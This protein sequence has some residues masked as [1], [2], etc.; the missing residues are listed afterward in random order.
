MRLIAA[1]LPLVLFFTV[2]EIFENVKIA[3]LSAVIFSQTYF[4]A[5]L[6]PSL[7]RQYIT[8][9]FLVLA[10]FVLVR[11]HKK[12]SSRVWSWTIPLVLFLFGLA[13]YHYTVAYWV[14]PIVGA[15]FLFERLIPSIPR[16]LL[17]AIKAIRLTDE[18]KLLRAEYLLLF[19]VF[20]VSWTALVGLT[21][22]VINLHNEIYLIT[23]GKPAGTTG[24]YQTS[25]LTG[26]PAGPITTAWLALDAALGALGFIYFVFNY[27]KRSEHAFWGIG[28]L[29]MFVAV[30]IWI[31][32]SFAGGLIYL[33]RVYLL[34]LI[35]FVAFAAGLLVALPKKFRVFLFLFL[36]L[37]LPMNMLLASHQRYVLYHKEAEIVPTDAL[38]Q[39]IIREPSF[40][41]SVWLDTF[42]ANNTIVYADDPTGIRSL[43]YLHEDYRV[44][45][46][47]ETPLN[48]TGSGLFAFHYYNLV[49]G[50]WQ[51]GERTYSD[52]SVDDVLNRTSV[53]YNNGEAA[54]VSFP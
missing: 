33:D 45:S 23:G 47:V 39:N 13:T 38:I 5:F 52:F 2:K 31:T 15:A 12:R 40:V 8:E 29:V 34:G 24:K 20:F 21:P 48:Y 22:F 4:N 49:H 19:M 50:L 7:M 51:T 36:F 14:I 3:A 53:V 27:P 54:L 17:G 10:I 42:P 41:M 32:P 25:W 16:K 1:I 9:I 11:T 18:R 6:L 37:N 44:S 35:F 26:S 28:G 30:A 43:F 46:F